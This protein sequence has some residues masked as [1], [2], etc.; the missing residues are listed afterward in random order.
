MSWG[1]FGGQVQRSRSWFR[2]L[3]FCKGNSRARYPDGTRWQGRE[4]LSHITLTLSVDTYLAREG[5]PKRSKIG[6]PHAC[7]GLYI[8]VRSVQSRECT[9]TRARGQ[10]DREYK[11]ENNRE[12]GVARDRPGR[13]SGRVGMVPGGTGK[14]PLTIKRRQIDNETNTEQDLNINHTNLIM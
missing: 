1:R 2:S 11:Q 7:Q 13:A 6:F 9:N 8:L 3:I 14:V 12:P 4:N 5:K 10:T